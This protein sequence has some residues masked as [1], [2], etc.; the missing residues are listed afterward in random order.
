MPSFHY[1]EPSGN[2]SIQPQEHRTENIPDTQRP[3]ETQDQQT[4]NIDFPIEQAEGKQDFAMDEDPYAFED[5]Q[6]FCQD[7]PGREELLRSFEKLDLQGKK[8]Q[9]K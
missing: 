9:Q 3:L 4:P 2:Q 7:L 6:D 1:P 8:K 5:L